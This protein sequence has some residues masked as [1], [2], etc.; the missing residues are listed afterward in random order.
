MKLIEEQITSS[1]EKRI[2]F[3]TNEKELEL[4]YGI[5]LKASEHFPKCL[6]TEQSYYRILNMKRNFKKYF[7]RKKNREEVD[8][9]KWLKE[10]GLGDFK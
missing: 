10:N 1:G 8:V 6:E 4:L 5:I 7:E 2:L 3:G 9:D